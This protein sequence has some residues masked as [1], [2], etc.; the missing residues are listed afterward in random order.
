M[1]VFLDTEFT[2]LHQNTTLISLALVAENGEEFYAEFIDY[3]Q[4]QIT[5]W[6]QDNVLTKLELVS[7]SEIPLRINKTI[8]IKSDSNVIVMNLRH[9]LLQFEKNEIW[10][11]VLAYDWVLFC[12]LFGGALSIP[13]NIYFAPFDLS[14]LLRAKKILENLNTFP[15]ELSRFDFLGWDNSSQHNTLSDAR[16]EKAC[17]EKIMSI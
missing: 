11:D 10:A 8:K 12:E 4:D 7:E 1:K 15:S 9:W 2:G 5:P 6:I 13:T 3:N 14:T 17:F 16:V